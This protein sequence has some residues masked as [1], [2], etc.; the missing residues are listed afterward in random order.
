MF[1]DS[2]KNKKEV[3]EDTSKN[4]KDNLNGIMIATI[5]EILK[6]MLGLPTLQDQL[7]ENTTNNVSDSSSIPP[8]DS[9]NTPT[10]TTSGR[11][12]LWDSDFAKKL[13]KLANVWDIRTKGIAGTNEWALKS[14]NP[15]GM[16]YGKTTYDAMV[17]NWAT[18]TDINGRVPSNETGTYIAFK[19]MSDGIAGWRAFWWVYI[20]W[21]K[22]NRFTPPHL[23][24]VKSALQIWWTDRLVTNPSFWID[25][26]LVELTDDDFAELCYRQ[27]EKESPALFKYMNTL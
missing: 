20:G 11:L 2:N 13:N 3:D 7:N 23:P 8:S 21:A 15:A 26:N 14:N 17:A 16:K 9:G 10:L 19:N 12:F 4:I 1:V 27:L 6:R 24:D 18:P 5:L 22:N 25:K